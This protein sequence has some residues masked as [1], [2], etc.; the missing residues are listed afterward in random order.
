MGGSRVSKAKVV[1]NTFVIFL[2]SGL[3]HGANW[4]FI[5]WGAYHAILFLPLIL[6]GKNRKYINI[7]AENR[8]FPTWREL[9]QMSLTFLLA[10]LGWIFF[11]SDTIHD[12]FSYIKGLSDFSTLNLPFGKTVLLISVT[13]SLLM[14]V[15]EWFQRDKQHGLCLDDVRMPGWVRWTIYIVLI[16]NIAVLTKTDAPFI[17]FQF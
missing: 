12:A 1:R 14:L 17:Y 16:A 2:V 15:V 8:L 11:R 10:T 13:M 3:W 5:A 9:S 7:V 4:T 6:L